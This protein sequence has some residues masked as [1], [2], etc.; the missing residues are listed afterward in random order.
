MPAR[1]WAT[2]GWRATIP[3][4]SPAALLATPAG[5]VGVSV[6]EVDYARPRPLIVDG[7]A[8]EWEAAS[9]RGLPALDSVP[10][11]MIAVVRGEPS[12]PVRQL[13]RRF[14]LRA[15]LVAAPREDPDAEVA[16]PHGKVAAALEQ[17][18]R[19]FRQSPQ[20]CTVG[21]CLLRLERPSLL[22]ESLAYSTLQSGREHAAWLAKRA[23]AR[24]VDSG[25]AAGGPSDSVAGHP[26]GDQR[27]AFHGRRVCVLRGDQFSEVVLRRGS[28]HN[29][30][31][32][33]M[34]EELCDVLD[35][36]GA[37]GEAIALR[38]EGPSF[39]SG[40][41]LDEFGTREDPA[42]AHLVRTSRS[43]AERLRRVS[44]R[45]VV[46]VHGACVGAGVELAAFGARL[47]A[48]P[49]TRFRLPEASFGLLPGAGGTVSLPARI[50]RH[51][52]LDLL[53][54]RRW[55]DAATA[56]RYGLVDELVE[57]VHLLSRL[58]ELAGG[59]WR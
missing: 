26:A 38:G 41:D 55:V 3:V 8:G 56:C 49:S 39:C 45:L 21:A 34:R 31:D 57:P 6:L 40:G 11:A 35:A 2:R 44:D 22:S 50:G 9:V 19:G 54:T 20:A 12:P 58:R 24:V 25:G 15:M 30:M 37:G 32:A 52:L 7:T 43:V 5:A 46:A 29:A 53:V 4:L 51:R 1:A 47:I 27:C 28:R 36:L 33:I 42:H 10:A 18:C 23:A 13:L 16:A 17:W 48:T 59:R 14:D